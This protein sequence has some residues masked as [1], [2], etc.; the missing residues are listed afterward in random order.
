MKTHIIYFSATYTTRT[1]C[2]GIARR[3]GG[4]IVEHDITNE[5]PKENVEIG[6][7]DRVLFGAP[8]YCG[9]IP[10]MAA[11][12]IRNFVGHNTKAVTVVVYGNRAFDDAL[13]ELTR[14]VETNGFRVI[15]ASA[16]IGRHC[17]FPTV[18]TNRPDAE[19]E[20]KMEEFAC[21]CRKML[22]ADVNT[23][24]SIELPGNKEEY[25]PH[26][27][28]P[29]CPVPTDDCIN[30]GTCAELCP[31]GA[32]S[33]ADAHEVNADLCIACGR[34]VVVCPQ[35]G[36]HFTGDMYAASSVKF[37]EAN[38]VRQEPEFFFAEKE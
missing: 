6:P 11:E 32:I 21:T 20:K 34:C 22:E 23:W 8:V 27:R 13:L 26:G 1:V 28:V 15:A 10:E 7:D 3:I 35:H 25:C 37:T 18:A 9:R 38:A 24:K 14:L 12:R 4:D 5:A 29:F 31:T 33:R 16:F 30:C 19:D 17:I 2:Q 36:R